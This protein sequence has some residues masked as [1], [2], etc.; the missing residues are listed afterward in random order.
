MQLRN[1]IMTP[2]YNTCL[3]IDD[4]YIDNFVNKRLLKICDYADDIIV[5]PYPLKALESLREGSLK[6]EVIF[7]D[8]RMP[9]MDGFEFLKRYDEMEFDKE[10]IKIFMFSNSIDPKDIRK[11]EDNKYITDFIAKPLTPEVIRAL[12][13]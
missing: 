12:V 4:N 8:I 3:L 11:A 2:L 9:E 1:T 7:L 10:H 5:N 13:A 6:P